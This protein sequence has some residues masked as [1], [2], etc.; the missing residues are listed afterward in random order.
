MVKY[1]A[2]DR[3]VMIGVIWFGGA[4]AMYMA[5]DRFSFTVRA[6]GMLAWFLLVPGYAVYSRMRGGGDE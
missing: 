5:L 4:V 6:T 3:L 1:S 2:F